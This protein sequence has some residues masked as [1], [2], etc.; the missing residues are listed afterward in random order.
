ALPQSVLQIDG[1]RARSEFVGGTMQKLGVTWDVARV[2]AYKNAPDQLT[3]TDM[4]AEQ[5]EALNAYLDSTFQQLQSG[6]APP[7]SSDAFAKALQA[8]LQPPN[9]AR[10]L[11]LVDEVISPQALDQKLS[12]LVPGARFESEYEPFGHLQTAW[13]RRRQIAVIPVVGTISGG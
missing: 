6:V 13:G 7:L 4:S 10:E 9:T 5:R 3:R 8:A 2:G 1:L 11:G 12:E